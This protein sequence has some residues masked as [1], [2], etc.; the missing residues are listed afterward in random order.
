MSGERLS[1]RRIYLCLNFAKKALKSEKYHNWFSPAIPENRPKA[2]TRAPV[3][4]QGELKN[5]HFRT[6]RYQ[7]SPLPYLT[8]LLN[9]NF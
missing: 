7:N 1:E 2:N 9:D 8:M 5:V 6:P 3:P 4:K